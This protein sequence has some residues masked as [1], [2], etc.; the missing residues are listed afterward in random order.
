MPAERRPSLPL[1]IQLAAALVTAML[2]G[3]T[4][5]WVWFGWQ[6]QW[7]AWQ[8]EALE[9]GITLHAWL[10]DPVNRDPAPFTVTPLAAPFE[11]ATREAAEGAPLAPAGWFETAFSFLPGAATPDNPAAAGRIA[12]RIYSPKLHYPISTVESTASGADALRFGRIIR[13]LATYCGD[14]QVYVHTATT[15]WLRVEGPK[16]WGCASAPADHRLPLLLVLAGVLAAC[17]GW[18]A[19]LAG[20]I[21]RLAGDIETLSDHGNTGLLDTSGPEEVA[22]IARAANGMLHAER[23]RIARRAAILSGISH[24]LGTPAA[25]LRLRAALIGDDDL[26]RKF[27][28]DIDRMSEMSNSVLSFARHE[29]EAEDLREVSLTALLTA[30]ADDYA[31]AGDPVTLED[32]GNIELP[33]PRSIFQSGEPA[34]TVPLHD[35]RRILCTCRPMALRRAITNLIDNA[36]KYGGAAHL[37]L[38]TGPGTVAIHVDDEG[39]HLP[40]EELERLVEPFARGNNARARQGIGLGLTIVDSVARLHGGSLAFAARPQG[41]RA[42]L[43][44]RQ[45]IG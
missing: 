24:D 28:A 13:V 33:A 36:L 40:P 8:A 11:P 34:S 10:V 18:A 45:Q 23:E 26:R 27:E 32:P 31:D 41:T 35:R 39:A 20:R 7:R 15:G 9:A 38:T 5:A 16:V 2:S 4:A 37:S 25:R 22:A 43:T 3:L 1:R 17:F 14:P 42:T 12:F 29:M 30:I 19:S 6:E 21:G 44:L